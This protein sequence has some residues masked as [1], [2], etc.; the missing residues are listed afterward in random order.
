M[1]TKVKMKHYQRIKV[2]DM[3]SF[4]L[5]VPKLYPRALILSLLTLKHDPDCLQNQKDFKSSVFIKY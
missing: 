3:S 2:A 4:K 1:D 5:V